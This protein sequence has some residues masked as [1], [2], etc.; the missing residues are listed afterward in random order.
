[1]LA[2]TSFNFFPGIDYAYNKSTWQS[3]KHNETTTAAK[4]VDV[5]KTTSAKTQREPWSLWA[6]DIA[7]SRQISSINVLAENIS[8]P[9]HKGNLSINLISFSSINH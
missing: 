1:M 5:Y 9:Q 8:T 4:A 2:G 6:A 7:K 3:S